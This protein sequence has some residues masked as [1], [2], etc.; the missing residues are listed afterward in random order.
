M[1][2]L[3]LCF[4]KAA[5]QFFFVFFYAACNT[6]IL[7]D[8]FLD[9]KS[10]LNVGSR[11]VAA[12][13]LSLCVCVLTLQAESKD[14]AEKPSE[15]A[16]KSGDKTEATEKVKKEGAEVSEREEETEEGGEAKTAPAGNTEVHDEIKRPV[17]KVTTRTFHLLF[18]L[19]ISLLIIF[20]IILYH[21]A[22]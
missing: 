18:S 12:R 13:H 10:G 22:L 4:T 1:C 8:L 2:C 20:S 5:T 16:E 21:F 7:H 6:K 14:E 17:H 19:L 15:S 11:G 9:P 3:F